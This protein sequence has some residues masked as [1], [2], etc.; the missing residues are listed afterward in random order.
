MPR[1]R[2][3]AFIPFT[4]PDGQVISN[5]HWKMQICVNCLFAWPCKNNS[6]EAFE[7]FSVEILIHHIPTI[8]YGAEPV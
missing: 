2:L 7:K 6:G 4:G 8:E 5:G 1:L 3:K